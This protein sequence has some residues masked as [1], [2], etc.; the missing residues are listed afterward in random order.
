MS[1]LTKEEIHE[2]F[3]QVGRK[4][5]RVKS[6]RKA[7]ACRLNG[8]KGGYPGPR[9]PKKEAQQPTKIVIVD[10]GGSDGT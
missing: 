5:G 10:P 4:G 8:L 2:Y 9:K 6:E 1:A 3:K 7:A